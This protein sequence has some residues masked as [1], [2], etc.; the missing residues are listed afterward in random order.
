MEDHVAWPITLHDRVQGDSYPCSLHTQYVSYPRAELQ[1]IPSP[2]QR[3]LA[4]LTLHALDALLRATSVDRVVQW[5]SWLLS[6]NLHH[7]SLPDA[8][9][10]VTRTLARTFPRHAVVVKNLHASADTTTL[11]AFQRA[12]YRLITSRQV[13]LFDGER[14]DYLSKG[15]VRR[16][17]KA[18]SQCTTYRIVEHSEFTPADVPRIVELYHKLYIQKHSPLNPQYNAWFVTRG[19]E[20]RWLEF[21]GLRHRSGSLDGVFGCFTAG[22]TTS[23]PFIGYD[24]SLGN[25]SG[26][27]RHLVALL[28]QQVGERGQCLNYSSGAGDF[29]RRRGGHPA[30]EF[31]A[32]YTR[33][34]PSPRQASFRLLELIANRIGRPFLERQQI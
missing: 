7:A 10:P 31:N 29:K 16:D 32:V 2:A 13:Y 34:L 8:V 22:N 33:H 26:L 9:G 5:S 25:N 6:T 20:E 28:L 3:S 4:R 24:T 23:T 11:E 27:Y 19:L 18:A 30:I 14:K 21:R 15:T 17:L 1:L 12:G